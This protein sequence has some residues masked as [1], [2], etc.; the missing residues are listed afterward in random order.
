MDYLVLGPFSAHLNQH[1]LTPSAPKL[2]RVLATLV[3]N[4]GETVPTRTLMRELWGDEP[5]SSSVTT[6]QTYI[7]N[8]RKWLI[9]STGR[10]TEEVARSS[11]VTGPGGYRLVLDGAIDI[12]RFQKFALLGQ[13]ALAHGDDTLGVR[14]LSDAL[15]IWRGSALSDLSAGVVLESWKRYAEES[16]LATVDHLVSAK[17]RLGMHREVLTDLAGI[18]P[19][20]PT[21]EN[22]H[23]HLMRALYLV[24]RRAQ[25]LEVYRSLHERLVQDLGIEPDRL[26]QQ[27]H[28]AILRPESASSVATRA[29]NCPK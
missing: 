2:R 6:L 4:A 7:L 20:N 1:D 14:R 11:L 27:L 9:T 25:A 8:L 22:L 13:E 5:P 18:T 15:Q 24:G 21:H 26:A 16:R 17:F 28:S 12:L 29:R 10:T 19:M 23:V 3:L